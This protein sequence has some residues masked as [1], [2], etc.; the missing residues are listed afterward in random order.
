MRTSPRLRLCRDGT[1]PWKRTGGRSPVDSGRLRHWRRFNLAEAVAGEPLAGERRRG[2]TAA[3]CRP[4]SCRTAARRDLTPV[5]VPDV[6]SPLATSRLSPGQSASRA[7]PVTM[8]WWAGRSRDRDRI[9]APTGRCG[10]GE[11][12]ADGARDI[13]AGS[14]RGWTRAGS[15]TPLRFNEVR[16]SAFP[17][18]A[19]QRRSTLVYVARDP[20]VTW[21]G[22]KPRRRAPHL[23][24]QVRKWSDRIP[25]AARRHR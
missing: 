12:T 1:V 7:L 4:C 17:A 18:A 11:G 13:H 23:M 2:G 16:R 14:W 19:T 21:F 3:G 24:T 22:G 6:R 15:S 5:S 8:G 25:A 9:A 10:E 20:T